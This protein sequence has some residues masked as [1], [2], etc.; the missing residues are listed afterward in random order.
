MAGTEDLVG[1]VVM[2]GWVG[3]GRASPFVLQEL[4]DFQGLF[5]LGGGGVQGWNCG[6][7]CAS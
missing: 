3:V 4:A 5:L 2:E 1:L 7:F 6:A